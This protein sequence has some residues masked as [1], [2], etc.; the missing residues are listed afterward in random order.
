[1]K[2]FSGGH[3][4]RAS[5]LRSQDE[6][7]IPVSPLNR[8]LLLRIEKLCFFHN[9]MYN[10]ALTVQIDGI[11]FKYY[12]ILPGLQISRR[13][14]NP[15]ERVFKG[16]VVKYNGKGADEVVITRNMLAAT[17]AILFLVWTSSL[18]TDAQRNCFLF[19]LHSGF[20]L[21][22][23]PSDKNV[24]SFCVY[25]RANPRTDVSIGFPSYF[26]MFACC[27]SSLC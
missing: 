18:T 19:C 7:S 26:F 21:F 2:E 15:V 4:S 16:L 8:L 12:I 24:R 17:E 9:F 6:G 14:A 1:M 20:Q 13:K 5:S 10:N 3:R 23:T 22:L 11:F 25:R 27:V